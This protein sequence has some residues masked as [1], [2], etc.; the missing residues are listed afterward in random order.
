M[1]TLT[2]QPPILPEKPEKVFKSSDKR[3]ESLRRSSAKSAILHREKTLERYRKCYY[4]RKELMRLR[5]I[6]IF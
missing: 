3:R 2:K 1:E 4:L 5:S 6:D